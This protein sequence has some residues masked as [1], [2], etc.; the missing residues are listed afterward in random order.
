MTTHGSQDPF[1]EPKPLPGSKKPSEELFDPT[2]P[3][4]PATGAHEAGEPTR[5]PI[6]DEIIAH[7]REEVAAAKART[8][9]AELEAMVAQEEPPR[10]FFAAVTTHASAND[11]AVIA[12]VK[13]KSPSAGLIRSEYAG[14]SFRPEFIAQRYHEAG[15]RAISCL[16]DEKFFGGHPSFIRRIKDAVPLPVIRK[17]FLIDPWQLWESRAAG[18][19]AVLLIAE[20]LNQ[21]MLLDML[22]LAQQLQLTVLLEVHTPENLLRVRPHV[23]FPHPSYALLGINNRDL[24]KME[25]DL[26]HTIRLAD[27]VENRSVLVSESGIRT[28]QD[29]KRL[30]GVGVQIVLVGEHLMRQEDPGAALKALLS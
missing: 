15:A 17:D 7:K 19:D 25:V 18:A 29:L 14:D 8:S 12:E 20:C 5:I 9:L 4:A 26:G 24:S 6:L 27:M 2:L 1:P 11:T 16:T 23:G 21:S 22:I 3:P 28:P 30:R 10:N 13:R